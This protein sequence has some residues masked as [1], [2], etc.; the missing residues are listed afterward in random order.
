MANE[1]FDVDD[2]AVIGIWEQA[3]Y[4]EVSRRSP[5]FFLGID[6][7]EDSFDTKP[8]REVDASSMAR[9]SNAVK[10]ARAA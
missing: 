10:R 2:P 7:A 9:L 4:N 1:W 8:V 6:W 3:L 5:A